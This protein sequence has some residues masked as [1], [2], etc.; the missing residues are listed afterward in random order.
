MVASKF[1]FA[2][3]LLFL[4][5]PLSAG[6][7]ISG[8]ASENHSSGNTV[9]SVATSSDPDLP[10]VKLCVTPDPKVPSSAFETFRSAPSGRSGYWVNYQCKQECPAW[11]Q[12]LVPAY[13]DD[14][15]TLIPN[16]RQLETP[17]QAM[18]FVVDG[19]GGHLAFSS[20]GDKTVLAHSGAGGTRYYLAPMEKLEQSSS[21]RVVMVRWEKGY[22]ASFFQ[23]PFSTPVTWGWFSRTSEKGTNIRDLNK[24]VASI[25]LWAHDNLSNGN[26][27]GTIG[28][29]MGTNATFG[30]VL[31]HGLDP[32]IDYQLFVGGPNMW[33]LNAQCGRRHYAKG[34]C[35]LDGVTTC[36]SDQDCRAVGE[37]G[38]CTRPSNYTTIDKLFEDMPN[39]VHATDACDIRV[40]DES[41]APYPPFDESSMG[42]THPADWNI[43]HRVDFLVNVGGKQAATFEE[44]IGGDEYWGL[45][46]FP[47]V[48]NKIQPAENKHWYFYPDSHHCGALDSDSAEALDVIRERMD[49]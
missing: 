34:Y 30:P 43:D 35:D 3:K 17:K 32:I 12:C 31:W 24:R 46:N 4:L 11:R 7:G 40:S 29:S 13:S 19:M 37:N 28:C 9:E 47:F 14:G 5:L 25:I 16:G 15:G 48:Y 49:L 10:V 1:S 41:T 39:H 27:F 6:F 18:A 8:C 21:T 2:S 44:G 45:G 42:F 38:H 26:M 20:D 33:D 22:T 36:A 23:P